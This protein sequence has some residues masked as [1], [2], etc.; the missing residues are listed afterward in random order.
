[1]HRIMSYKLQFNKSD[2]INN[3]PPKKDKKL[4]QTCLKKRKVKKLKHSKNTLNSI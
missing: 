4:Q 1:M 2:A 3:S